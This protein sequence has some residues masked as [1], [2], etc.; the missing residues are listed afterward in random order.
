MQPLT[1]STV[2]LLYTVKEKD[3]NPDKKPD[4]KPYPLFYG[5]LE[6]I[7]QKQEENPLFLLFCYFIFVT[8]IFEE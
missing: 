5:F 2:Q 1:I 8:F 6:F 7:K 4:R 3:R